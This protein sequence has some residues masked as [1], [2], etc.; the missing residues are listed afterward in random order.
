[1]LWGGV[2]R[3]LW[4]R[5][6]IAGR[7]QGRGIF[8]LLKVKFIKSIEKS[9]SSGLGELATMKISTSSPNYIYLSVKNHNRFKPALSCWQPRLPRLGR[10]SL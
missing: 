10:R 2:W 7:A 4:T 3:G 6:G 8:S 1:M 5:R 9:E